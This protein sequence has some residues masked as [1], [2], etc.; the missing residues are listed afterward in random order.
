MTPQE[1]KFI[2]FWSQKRKTWKWNAHFKK[3]FFKIVLPFATLVDLVN[4]FIIGDTTYNFFSFS[5][6]LTL[7]GNILFFS[8]AI[9]MLTGITEWNY[10]ENKY[11][12]IMRK[13]K[14]KFA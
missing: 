11:W 9:I 2:A 13:N 10:N 4:Y 3:T 1:E 5:H 12:R 8:V 6:L 14:D 7:I